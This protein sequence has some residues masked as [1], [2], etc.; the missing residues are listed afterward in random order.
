MTDILKRLQPYVD[1]MAETCHKAVEVD[2]ED[3]NDAVGE[4][5]RLNAWSK[6]AAEVMMTIAKSNPSDPSG[7]EACIIAAKNFIEWAA[8]GQPQRS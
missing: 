2:F 5:E 1:F 6:R 4:I 3:L 7:Y 8:V